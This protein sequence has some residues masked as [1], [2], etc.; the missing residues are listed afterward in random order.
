MGILRPCLGSFWWHPPLHYRAWQ[1]QPSINHRHNY[2]FVR[3]PASRNVQL[4]PPS[5]FKGASK[6]SIESL[7]YWTKLHTKVLELEQ[8]RLKPSVPRPTWSICFSWIQLVGK[9]GPRQSVAMK[10]QNTEPVWRESSKFGQ[11]HQYSPLSVES[12]FLV[13]A[14]LPISPLFTY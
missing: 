5:R 1:G 6:T 8:S 7:W 3:R 2:P 14:A 9:T 10:C 12:P 13:V 4:T 11:S